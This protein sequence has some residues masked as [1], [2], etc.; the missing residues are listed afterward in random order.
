MFEEHAHFG[1]VAETAIL[2]VEAEVRLMEMDDQRRRVAF[3]LA[4]DVRFFGDCRHDVSFYIFLSRLYIPYGSGYF[5]A[6]RFSCAP[7]SAVVFLVE[8]R[9]SLRFG[10]VAPFTPAFA[11]VAEVGV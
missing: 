9:C 2:L 1:L 4:K 6:T 3:E 7:L 10:L 11:L 5:L 8:S